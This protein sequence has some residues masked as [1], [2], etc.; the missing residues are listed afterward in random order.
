MR[1][2][3]EWGCLCWPFGE[4]PVAFAAPLAPFGHCG[5]VASHRHTT[6]DW[7]IWRFR[8]LISLSAHLKAA[9][10]LRWS[11]DS[12]AFPVLP[13]G[14]GLIKQIARPAVLGPA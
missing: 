6:L 1:D 10:G 3:M 5:E 8:G 11:P 2:G 7:F 9:V 4:W 12:S 13:F 14:I